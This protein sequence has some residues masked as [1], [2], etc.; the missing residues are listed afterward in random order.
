M[1]RQDDFDRG[2]ANRREVLGDE[3]VARSTA[4]ATSLNAEFQA[5]FTQWAWHDVWGRPGLDRRTRR[6]LVLGMTMALARW[7][8]FEIHCRA[9]LRGGVPIADVKE[10]L[11]QGAI[12]CGVPAANTAFR[13]TADLCRAEG[14][15]LEPMPLVD[16]PRVQRH[17]TFSVPQLRVAL[18]GTEHGLP[19]MLGH[20]LGIDHTMFDAL[21][22]ELAHD[23]PVLR[24]DHRGHGESACPPGPYTL[25]DL[26]DDAARLIR[27][28][29]RGPVI[30]VGLS[31]GGMV[32][33]GLAIR[34]PELVRAI[35]LANTTARN[36]EAAKPIWA[37]RIA[38]VEA[39][40][41]APLVDATLERWLTASFRAAQ[42]AL[43]ESVRALLQRCDPRGYVAC[44][45]AVANV[46]WLDRLHTIRC[47]T[48]VI[49]GRHDAGTT[50]AMAQAIADRVPGAQ[51][52]ELL[53]AAHLSVIEQPQH[54]A[55]LVTAFLQRVA[56]GG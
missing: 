36:P 38:T 41:M 5:L 48:L 54:F 25:D 35:V 1:N 31:M 26:V 2:L 56:A 43:V 17:H 23:H 18:Q 6:L 55:A 12:Y 3:W 24:H 22:A 52:L 34:H 39:N 10:A 28:W 21:A 46:D 11:L 9:A 50:P 32:A 19:V 33:Q 47:P 20:A 16:G 14:I 42:P 40:G 51:Q 30:Y 27:E 15:A 7:E 13:I 44:S 37:E 53:E 49:A 29:G 4:S 45:H 8:E